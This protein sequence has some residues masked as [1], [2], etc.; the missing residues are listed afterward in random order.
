M[1]F[2]IVA[3]LHGK[4][5]VNFVVRVK[6][7]RRWSCFFVNF[8][9]SSFVREKGRRFTYAGYLPHDADRSGGCGR[10]WYTGGP[11]ETVIHRGLKKENA[12]P[13]WPRKVLPHTIHSFF[14]E[15][16]TNFSI[17]KKQRSPSPVEHRENYYKKLGDHCAYKIECKWSNVVFYVPRKYTCWVMREEE[18]AMTTVKWSLY[19]GC[20]FFYRRQS[21]KKFFFRVNFFVGRYGLASKNYR[22]S[23]DILF[24]PN[25]FSTERGWTVEVWF[26][27]VRIFKKFKCLL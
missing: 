1:R 25:F 3:V 12:N 19:P 20:T 15:R 26:D 13:L 17:D 18:R 24:D 23:P 10:G 9:K 8:K 27:R 6:K 5:G 4:I 22:R 11:R 16:A 7:K 14:P 2:F 21:W